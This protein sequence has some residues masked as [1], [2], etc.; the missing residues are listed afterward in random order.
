MTGK[1]RA[2]PSRHAQALR[3]IQIEP[4]AED[5]DVAELTTRPGRRTRIARGVERALTTSLLVILLVIIT[6]IVAASLSARANTLIAQTLHIDI[7]A[8]I[9][10]L[11]RLIEQLH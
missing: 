1:S 9:A 4:S 5:T 10:Y 2:R 3:N 8:E 11:L 6:L 7:R